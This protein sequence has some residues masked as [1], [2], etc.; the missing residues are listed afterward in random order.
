MSLDQPIHMDEHEGFVIV[1][2][3]EKNEVTGKWTRQWRVDR[4]GETLIPP[5]PER[6][7]E[8]DTMLEARNSGVEAAREFIR[9]S[10]D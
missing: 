4:D 8:F 9:V 10:R 5:F 7:I 6:N 3:P 1:V 2:F